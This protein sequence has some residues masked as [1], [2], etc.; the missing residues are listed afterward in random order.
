VVLLLTLA[1]TSIIGTLIPQ[2]ES[3]AQ[4]TKAFG[5]FLYRFFVVFDF[6][7][8]YHS[9]WFQLLILLLTANIVVC[10]IDRFSAVWKIVFVKNPHFNVS[11]FR[12]L[13]DREEFEEERPPDQL[14]KRYAPV[15]ERGFGRSRVEQ[16]EKGFCIFAE[17]WRW[18]RL[19]VYVV[20]L[21]IVLMLFGSLIGSL[22]GFD[23]FVNIPE[24][25]TINSVRIRNSGST[26]PL[27]FSIRCDDFDVSFYE[28]GAPREF[29]S[30]LTVIEGGKPAFTKDIIV[31]DPL[32]YRGINVFQSSYGR[33]PPGRVELNVT[34]KGSGS[35]FKKEVRFGSPIDLPEGMGTFEL[36]D[37]T[38]SANFRG[39]NLGESFIGVL[40]PKTGTP[41][42]I[43]LP[44]RFPS[45]D[46]MRK[47]AQVFAV[48]GY[49]ERYYTGLQV[50]KDPG[51]WVVYSGFILMIAG[52]VITFFMSH[53]SVCIEVTRRG[54]KSRVM[55]SGT[56]HKN[57]VGMQNKVA[58][59]SNRLKGPASTS[60]S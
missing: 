4:Y 57:P 38:S 30:R 21:S 2:N 7:D 12:K 49:D 54:K 24:G 33:L 40:V 55:I 32:R 53:Q 45:F 11:R 34:S 3:P 60:E 41:V 5:D 36:K 18:T 43:I 14:Q 31:N 16:T 27:D 6:F 13:P 8:M 37:F 17:K 20:H 50:T 23:G 52:C 48:E 56:A 51:V 42:E 9:W 58:R 22:F 10:S 44:L 25:E 59:I 47:G 19:G 1:G 26:R 39:H 35:I 29:R 15:V 28:S 46:K